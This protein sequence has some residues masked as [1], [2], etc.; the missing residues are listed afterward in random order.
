MRPLPGPVFVADSLETASPSS[1]T[2][3]PLSMSFVPECERILRD[4]QTAKPAFSSSDDPSAAG[5]GN[6]WDRVVYFRAFRI[7]NFEVSL[8]Y[9][10]GSDQDH[11]DSMHLFPGVVQARCCGGSG[12]HRLQGGRRVL[13]VH[14]R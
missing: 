7:G 8:N 12:G 14:R 1:S 5:K 11:L 3:H 13:C 2:V 4:A 10:A 9:V 6:L